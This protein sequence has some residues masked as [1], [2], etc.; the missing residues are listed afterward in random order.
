[1]NRK[2]NQTRGQSNYHTRDWSITNKTNQP[3]ASNKME[4]IVVFSLA[5]VQQAPLLAQRKLLLGLLQ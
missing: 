2:I 3:W 4:G 1:M 5:A